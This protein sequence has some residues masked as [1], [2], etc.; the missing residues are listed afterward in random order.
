MARYKNLITS[1]F[2][3]RLRAFRA[4][5]GISQERMAELLRMSPR[6]YFDIEHGKYGLSAASLCFFLIALS[7]R[8]VTEL[9]KAFRETV[10]KSEKA[11]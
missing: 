11:A 8:E 1:F 10:E 9:L 4:E 6:S 5:R 3:L 7:E 2:M